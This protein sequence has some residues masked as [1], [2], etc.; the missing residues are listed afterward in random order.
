MVDHH[1]LNSSNARKYLVDKMGSALT[2]LYYLINQKYFETVA[3]QV[4]ANNTFV[5]KFEEFVKDEPLRVDRL[6]N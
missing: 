2:L 1:D 3:K 6:E 4:E 5:K